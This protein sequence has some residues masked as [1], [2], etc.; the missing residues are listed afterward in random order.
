MTKTLYSNFPLGHVGKAIN[1]C[2]NRMP[3]EMYSSS[4]MEVRMAGNILYINVGANHNRCEIRTAFDP[5]TGELFDYK[6]IDQR[7]LVRVMHACGWPRKLIAHFL[8]LS[9]YQVTNILECHV[10]HVHDR[11]TDTGYPRYD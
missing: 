10:H 11:Y 7:K 9:Y 6:D 5:D 3:P 4:D 2:L 1:N 8:F